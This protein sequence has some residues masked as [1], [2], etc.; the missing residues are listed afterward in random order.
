MGYDGSSLAQCIEV[1][2]PCTEINYQN[3]YCW[4]L[5]ED[6]LRF[7]TQ[8]ALDNRNVLKQLTALAVQ[9]L[10]LSLG[11]FHLG[12]SF[13]KMGPNLQLRVFPFLW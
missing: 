8:F 6:I 10:T 2:T 1:N 13:G 11:S 3:I 9:F 4:N 5:S 7:K 12:V